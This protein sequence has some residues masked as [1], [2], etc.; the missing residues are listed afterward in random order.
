MPHS[1]ISAAEPATNGAAMLVPENVLYPPLFD[2]DKIFTAG[3]TISGYEYTIFIVYPRP[4]K[5]VILSLSE[6]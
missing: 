1:I 6:S 4:E 5:L 3:A 2:V